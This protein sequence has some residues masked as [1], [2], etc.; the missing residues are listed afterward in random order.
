[1]SKGQ[2]TRYWVHESKEMLVDR[3]EGKLS[4]SCDINMEGKILMTKCT[5]GMEVVV[6]GKEEVENW[7]E[8]SMYEGSIKKSKGRKG[9]KD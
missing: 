9:E 3:W 4:T 5:E 8:L 2:E 6:E 1:M 7:P